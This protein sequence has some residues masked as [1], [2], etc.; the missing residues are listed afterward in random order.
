M[1]CLPCGAIGLSSCVCLAARYQFERG[2]TE[3]NIAT[4]HPQSRHT[5]AA[6]RVCAAVPLT[7]S[8]TGDMW[9]VPLQTSAGEDGAAQGQLEE[10]LRQAGSALPAV[11]RALALAEAPEPALRPADAPGA[12]QQVTMADIH[13][14]TQPAI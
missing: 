9:R 11:Q 14:A 5:C 12:M 6:T 8:L 2:S 4:A 10:L 7:L 1:A 3:L 13:L